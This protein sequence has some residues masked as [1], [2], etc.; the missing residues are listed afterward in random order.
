MIGGGG[1]GNSAVPPDQARVNPYLKST[2][3]PAGSKTGS[4]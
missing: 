2:G 3:K 1:G 4:M